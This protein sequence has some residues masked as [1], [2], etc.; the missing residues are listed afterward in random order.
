GIPATLDDGSPFPH[1]ELIVL[2]TGVVIVVTMGQALILPSVVRW[3]RIPCD[4][5]VA[6]EEW[7]AESGALNEALAALPDLAARL[8]T[9][10][11]VA[12]A[13]RVASQAQA[14]ALAL[15]CRAADADA[16]EPE[17][18]P[19][20]LTDDAA[21]LRLAL[22]AERRAVVVRLRDS[23]AIDDTVLR[24]LQGHLDAEELHLLRHVPVE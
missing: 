15:R 21:A 6:H 12:E 5:S 10:P 3:A 17:P 19:Q 13:V 8:N 4:R 16:V 24:R 7:L 2:V 1:R 18:H 9:A 22:V 23:G 14:D 20:R 11:A